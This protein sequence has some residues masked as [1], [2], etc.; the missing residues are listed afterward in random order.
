MMPTI[1]QHQGAI[2]GRPQLKYASFSFEGRSCFLVKLVLEFLLGKL[3]P[4]GT[5][6]TEFNTQS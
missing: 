2:G 1:R 4:Y 5:C 6:S 3:L